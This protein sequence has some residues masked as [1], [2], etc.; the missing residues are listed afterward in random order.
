MF[1]GEVREAIT[2]PGSSC[3]LSGGSQCSAALTW[4]SKNAQVCRASVRR[5]RVCAALGTKVSGR[6]D[7]LTHQAIVGDSSHNASNGHASHST[8]GRCSASS[9]ASSSASAGPTH[10][11]RHVAAA[12][13]LS[14]RATS[15]EVCHCSR[16]R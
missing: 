3:R 15:L 16:W 14:R 7:W 2:G 6:R 10:I 5:K 11:C 13:V 4:L 1:V 12:V 9:T 8:I